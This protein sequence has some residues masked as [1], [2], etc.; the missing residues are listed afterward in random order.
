MKPKINRFWGAV[1]L[2]LILLTLIL[3]IVGAKKG[4]LLVRSDA[5]PEETVKTFFASVTAGNYEQANACLENYSSLGLETPSSSQKWNALLASYAYRIPGEAER[6]GDTAVQAVRL[7]YLDLNA[8]DK[9][10]IT[11]VRQ[12]GEEGTQPVYPSLEELL[13][14]PED[15]YTT[16]ELQVTL[17]YTDGQWLIFADDGLLN[18]LAGGK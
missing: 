9:A 15:F 5:K 2:G 7:R 14:R 3:C 8:L 17:H 16:T 11:P 1:T 4:A 13:A 6:K 10:L 12:E 18:A